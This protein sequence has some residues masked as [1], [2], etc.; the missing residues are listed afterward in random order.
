MEQEKRLLQNTV[1]YAIGNFGSK[2]LSFLL[3]PLFS[4]YV[5][6]EDFGTYDIIVITATLMVPIVT[7]QLSDGVYRWLLD[8]AMKKVSLHIST[9][10]SSS[11]FIILMNLVVLAV[12]FY[13]ARSYFL[14]G[15]ENGW[16]L[17]NY[18]F[19]L[20]LLPYFQQIAR[21]LQQN[22]L[23]AA[24]GIVNSLILVI[25]NVVFL[26]V[27]NWGLKA[28][29][30]SMV[31]ANYI[32][33]AVI[34]YRIGF[35]RYLSIKCFDRRIA[36]KL[37]FYSVP[38]IPN[39]IS[40]W[41]ISSA[42]RYIIINYLG[43]DENGIFAMAVRI[44]AILVMVNSIFSLAWQESAITEYSSQNRDSFYSKIFKYYFRLELV[45]IIVLLP[46]TKIIILYFV[47]GTFGE[48]WKYTPF[49]YLGVAFS[50]FSAFLGTGY[51]S[52]K[53]TMGA[54]YTTIFG[55]VVNLIVSFSLIKSYGLFGAAVGSMVGFLVTWILRV[56]QTRRFF[57]LNF[58]F[59]DFVK[60]FML[61]LIST[62]AIY[63]IDDFGYLLFLT[64]ILVIIC[65]LLYRADVKA[66]SYY[67]KNKILKKKLNKA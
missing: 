11:A 34:A 37:V 36:Y 67:F 10:V 53:S 31:I 14:R 29:L 24:A 4:F 18:L 63:F 3:V 35:L 16:L 43:E 54:F 19:S 66:I 15:L 57:T 40:W 64:L 48:A 28:L 23:Y 38:L 12:V 22:R 13:V 62:T 44:T 58:N 26:V 5:T 9:V 39:I 61:F 17:L 65:G 6:R 56:F 7:L 47:D 20:C 32:V 55:S 8:V 33:I 59:G 50:A 45:A 51:L 60:L 1:I 41:L 30:L 2:L 52:T 49:L 25:C 42:N 21:G 46:V 27:F